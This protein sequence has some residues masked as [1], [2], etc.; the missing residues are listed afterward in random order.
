MRYG[1][2]YGALRTGVSL[3]FIGEIHLPLVSHICIRELGQ[4]G[5]DN[6]LF[7]ICAKALPKPLLGYH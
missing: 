3:K 2:K 5:S 6:G 7:P 1:G 4:I